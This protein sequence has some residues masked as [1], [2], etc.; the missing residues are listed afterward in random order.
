MTR[1]I[2][3]GAAAVVLVLIITIGSITRH[4]RSPSTAGRHG[5]AK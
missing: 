1:V 2:I 3:I 4:K 5:K